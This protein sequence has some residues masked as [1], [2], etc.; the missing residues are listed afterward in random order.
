MSVMESTIA[1]DSDARLAGF[2]R[3]IRE[4]EEG[5]TKRNT[6]QP[7]EIELLLDIQICNIPPAR[8]ATL[9]KRYSRA[10]ERQ[11]EDGSNEMLKLSE[12]LRRSEP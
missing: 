12:Y 4:L 5:R 3:L 2:R 1:I 8:R 9:L 7:W 11:L 10:V 6:F